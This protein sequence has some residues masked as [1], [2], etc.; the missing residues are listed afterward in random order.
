MTQNLSKYR[1]LGNEALW[2]PQI[3]YEVPPPNSLVRDGYEYG[4]GTDN[5][6]QEGASNSLL[7]GAADF[8]SKLLGGIGAVLGGAIEAGVGLLGAVVDG[9]VGLIQGIASA[10][11]NLFGG[12]SSNPYPPPAPP[13]IFN[14]IKTNLEAVLQPGFDQVDALL[15]DSAGIGDETKTINQ[16]M[17]ELIDPENDNSELWVMQK[18]INKLD[19]ERNDL[20][21]KMI[22]L[23]RNMIEAQS[24]F[25]SRTMFVPG[26]GTGSYD[27]Y[28]S[29]TKSGLQWKVEAKGT[30]TG[31]YTL[32]SA[33]TNNGNWEPVI[34]FETVPNQSATPRIRY[35]SGAMYS[36][37][38]NY[39]VRKAEHFIRD[40]E[41][42]Y[43]S[44]PYDSWY[45]HPEMTLPVEH[46]GPHDLYYRVTWGAATNG[47]YYGFRIRR[48]GTTILQWGTFTN[49]GPQFPWE[50]GVRTRT[51]SEYGI[52]LVEGDTLTFE[53]YSD[54]G[55]ASQ[56]SVDYAVRKISWL[57]EPEIV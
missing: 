51:I 23:N 31:Q 8:F 48:N 49:V 12:S 29:V 41:V 28:F 13:A 46:T 21:D 35:H 9:V 3:V 19:D 32:V 2:T 53:T 7:A 25:V 57:E 52:E 30:W 18:K 42:G 44:T 22:E 17:R 36:T 24:E 50:S 5:V 47:D 33:Y 15:V 14:P 54:A 55:T 34:D 6:D 45:A 20:Q 1:E 40:K 56:R 26:G 16:Q 27:D 43:F 38:I 10:I 39:W 11:G 4:E 37:L